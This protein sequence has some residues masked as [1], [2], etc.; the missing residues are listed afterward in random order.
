MTNLEEYRA[1]I[2]EIDK[3][4]I[5]KVDERMRIAED[6]AKYK[7]ANDMKIVD[8]AREHAL[9]EK[10]TDDSA[11][12]MAYYNRMMFSLLMEMS[13][14]HQRQ[15]TD[16]ESKVVKEIRNAIQNTPSVFPEK[17]VVACQGVQGAYSQNACEKMFKMPKI[18]Y[19]KNF[20]GVFA[21]IDKGLCRYG[22]LPVENSTAGTVNQVYDLMKAYDFHIV[23]SIK[24]K[25]EHSLLVNDGVQKSD[26]KEIISHEQAISQCEDYLRREF[27]DAKITVYEN[28]AAAAKYLAESG[29]KDAAAL[30]GEINGEYYSLIP[31]ER[32]VQD[33]DSNYTRFICITKPLEIYPGANKT[34]FMCVTDHTPGSLY[35]VM[36]AINAC[37]INITKLESRPIPNSD[38]DFQFYFDF[39][40]SVYTEEFVRLMNH[41]EGVCKE[42]RYMGSYI[43]L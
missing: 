31:L 42:F 34:S 24:V 18:V 1:K 9:M 8:P 23:K 12:D 37:G 4:L 7:Q 17:A 5:E 33:S 6:I 15:V 22:V 43:E 20:K 38:F 19:T 39:E 16:S 21:A 11:N 2:D 29:R 10:V 26:I 3:T 30:G 27:P 36:S 28:T 25:I 40:E 32:G 14:D 41:L 35:K 13:A